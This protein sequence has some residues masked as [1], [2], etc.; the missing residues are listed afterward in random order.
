MAFAEILAT[1]VYVDFGVLPLE[2][3]PGYRNARKVDDQDGR[4]R[5]LSSD[6]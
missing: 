6:Q 4:R 5:A 3:W 1:A 2:F